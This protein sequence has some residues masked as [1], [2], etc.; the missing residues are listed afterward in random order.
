[1][2]EPCANG[3]RCA[4]ISCSPTLLNSET[5]EFNTSTFEAQTPVHRHSQIQVDVQA[6]DLVTPVCGGTVVSAHPQRSDVSTNISAPT[7]G[8]PTMSIVPAPTNPK[9]AR[10]AD[11]VA[12]PI[13]RLRSLYWEGKVEGISRL[14]S[15]SE[16]LLPLPCVPDDELRN[17]IVSRTI[18]ENEHLFSI[19]TPINIDRLASLL[20]N[21]PN[22]PFVTSVLRGLHEGFWPWADTHH[23]I[24]PTT[25]DYFKP[26]EYEDNIKHFLRDQRNLEISLNRFSES[27]GPDLLPGMYAMPIHVIPKLYTVNFRLITNLSTGDFAP[28]TMIDKSEVTNL[29]L[30][31]ISELGAALI[32]F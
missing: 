16:C 17:E 5:C 27:F 20:I 25:K 30:D 18:S 26:R 32:A 31:T 28:N 4:E 7:A 1:M 11:N 13:K 23:N 29:P 19:V 24:Y 15:I 6:N 2:T 21:H 3:S 14:A 22:P 12:R 10:T 8:N 9:R